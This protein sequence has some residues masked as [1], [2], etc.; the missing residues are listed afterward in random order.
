MNIQ[1]RLL[2]LMG[3]AKSVPSKGNP[4]QA[5]VYAFAGAG[6]SQQAILTANDGADGDFFGDAVAVDQDTAIVGAYFKNVSN[7]IEQ[8]E[9]Y[10]YA[11]AGG[12]WSQ[13]ANLFASD[14][15]FLDQFG[16]SV[17]VNGDTAIV[18]AYQKQVG[19]NPLQGEAYV[20]VRSGSSWNEQQILLA[21]DGAA[22]D[23]FGYSVAVSG[24]IAIVGAATK[25][26]GNNTNQGQ[27]YIY[28]RSEDTWTEQ[29]TCAQ[30]PFRSISATEKCG[31][32]GQP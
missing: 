1:K 32:R 28:V 24:D 18:G 5:Y 20:Y 19:S 11:R 31:L 12:Q 21:S 6:W 23:E 26:V 25:K 4:G 22:L 10:V 7:N 30:V 3:I 17:A 29:P 2:F 8:G 13:Q 27:A 16:W 15:G 14:A 9:A